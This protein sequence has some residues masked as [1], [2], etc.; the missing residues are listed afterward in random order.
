MGYANGAV[1]ASAA[2]VS[3]SADDSDVNLEL[4]K[5]LELGTTDESI[6]NAISEDAVLLLN[7]S[8][9]TVG[10]ETNCQAHVHESESESRSLSDI[11]CS[12]SVE[13]AQ[14]LSEFRSR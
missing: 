1:C 14:D 5:P 12:S 9:T 10:P 7:T 13:L 6:A 4:D 8:T 11:A 2:C 3:E